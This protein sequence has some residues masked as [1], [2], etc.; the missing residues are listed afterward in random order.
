MGKQR[1]FNSAGGPLPTIAADRPLIV[2]D[3]DEV[4]LGF[5][6]GLDQWLSAQDLWLARDGFALNGNI[7]HKTGQA[8]ETSEVRQLL[9]GF[10]AE[11]AHDLAPIDGAVDALN[12]MED[13]ATIVFL[14]NLPEASSQA[15]RDNLDQ[16]GLTQPL[17]VNEGPKGP[18]LSTLSAGLDFAS[19]FLDDSPSNI[20]SAL[21]N[22]PHMEVIHFVA[23]D[24]FR[25][26][27][28]PMAGVKLFTGDW[29]DVA[30]YISAEIFT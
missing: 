5:V 9:H 11:R 14:S 27:I 18:A 21:E 20:T 28:S 8:V 13:R 4:V 3:V 6:A 1:I 2:C 30:R 10:F 15:R 16:L 17:I 25:D 22:V 12:S 29:R 26:Q 19:V 23:D 24:G 7:R